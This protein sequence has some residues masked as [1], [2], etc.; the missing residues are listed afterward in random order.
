MANSTVT[1]VSYGSFA[2][3]SFMA[4][5]FASYTK[6]KLT[7]EAFALAGAE[8]LYLP[9]TAINVV[10]TSP[11]QA[12]YTRTVIYNTYLA[13]AYGGGI[14]A[15]YSLYKNLSVSLA[16]D[17]LLAGVSYHSTRYDEY[18][19]NIGYTYYSSG[20]AQVF[21]PGIKAALRYSFGK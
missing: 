8:Y 10:I 15:A 6:H 13:F 14:E 17:C 12:Q 7:F 5:A 19:Q 11:G 16:A 20:L 4:G 21:M 9:N 2:Q 3:Y 18:I 1:S